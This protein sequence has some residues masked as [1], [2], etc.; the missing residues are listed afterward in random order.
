[1][2]IDDS[3][4]SGDPLNLWTVCKNHRHQVA[5]GCPDIK[6]QDRGYTKTNMAR[7]S[8]TKKYT[9]NIEPKPG[10]YCSLL[11]EEP[12]RHVVPSEFLS[13][14]GRFIGLKLGTKRLEKLSCWSPDSLYCQA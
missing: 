10:T 11:T 1:M 8:G 3:I 2:E 6:A 12:V 5:P 4:I 7:Y 13:Q 9:D 14:G